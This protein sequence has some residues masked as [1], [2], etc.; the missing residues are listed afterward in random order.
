VVH[1][2]DQEMI[3]V[4]QASQRNLEEWAPNQIEPVVRLYSYHVTQD[5]LASLDSAEFDHDHRAWTDGRNDLPRLST[6]LVESRSKRLVTTNQ[7]VE[8]STQ[9]SDVQRSMETCR[10]RQVIGVI[11]RVQT[12]QEPQALLRE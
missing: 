9:R 12:A 2:E 8:A 6:P 1:H 5:R 3:A 4:R 7:F 10:D 11:V